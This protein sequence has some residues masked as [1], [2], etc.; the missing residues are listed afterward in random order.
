MSI[1]NTRIGWVGTGN[2]GSP[3]SQCLIGEGA[4]VAVFDVVADNMSASVAAGARAGG[5][6]HDVAADAEF[7]FSMISD[8]DVLRAVAL[9]DG[10]VL[11]AMQAG[12][13]YV[14]MSTV[15]PEVSGEIA[16]AANTAG[17]A[18][19]RAPVSGSTILA[20][21]GNLTIMASGPGSAYERCEPLFVAMAAIQFYVG[22]GE[23]ARYM[24]LVL[25]LLAAS[26]IAALAEALTFGRKGGLDWNIMLD[27][28]GDSVVASP[29]IK[30]SLPPLK[31][32]DFSPAF[33]T[34]LMTK[35]MG[36]ICE[37][38]AS[39]GVPTEIADAVRQLYLATVAG[40]QGADN[41]TAAIRH[42]ERQVGLGEPE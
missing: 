10:G 39:V 6:N 1:A 26:T 19:V 9:G 22:E 5:S 31:A 30:Y 20:E 41:L 15:S 40:G 29:L 12:T 23:Q 2:M 21:A 32:R 11:S 18:F 13:V 37:A 17:I 24:K 7:V 4:S 16:V 35:D 28:I 38:A 34:D 42:I 27:V 36:L 14:D 25:N 3:M 33:S 8:D